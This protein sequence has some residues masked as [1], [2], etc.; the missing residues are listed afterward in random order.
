M[1]KGSDLWERMREHASH[2]TESLPYQT[3]I[4]IAGSQRVLI[5]NHRGMITYGKEKIIVNVKYGSVSVCGCNLE[6]AHMSNEQ[7]V[8]FGNIRNISLHRRD[9]S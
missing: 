3:I 2:G 4:E 8:I 7:L 9:E 5:E 6:V 1:W